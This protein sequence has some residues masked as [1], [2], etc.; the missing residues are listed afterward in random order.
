MN[1]QQLDNLPDDVII[2][3]ILPQ[4]NTQQKR[5][6]CSINRRFANICQNDLLWRHIREQEFPKSRKLPTMSEKQTLTFMKQPML[7]EIDPWVIS[8]IEN[9]RKR[10]VNANMYSDLHTMQYQPEHNVPSSLI[11]SRTG[12][13]YRN[14]SFRLDQA[15]SS[16]LPQYDEDDLVFD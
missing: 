1:L 7:K 12:L 4:L 9:R 6:L 5:R 15:L 10:F 2:N 8:A 16:P 3:V 13:P 11:N 14:V